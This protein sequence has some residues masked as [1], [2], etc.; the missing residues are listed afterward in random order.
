MA[1]DELSNEEIEALFSGITDSLGYEQARGQFMIYL[2]NEI[3]T[4]IAG[5]QS[6]PTNWLSSLFERISARADQSPVEEEAHVVRAR[7]REIA[8]RFF[9]QVTTRVTK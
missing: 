2:L 3:V 7:F 8:E 4:D 1:K 9:A 6:D 5:T